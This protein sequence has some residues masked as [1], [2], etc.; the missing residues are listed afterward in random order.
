[1]IQ[2][3]VYNHLG[4]SGN[5]LPRF[6]PY[7]HDDGRANTWGTGG[8]SRRPGLRRGA[9]LHHRQRPDVAGRL[10][11]RR[12]S[13]GR[14]ARAG[15]PQR[16]CTC[17]R[18]WPT[19]VAALSA[20]L[21]RPLTLIAES[22]LNDPRLITPRAAGGYGLDAQWNDD[23]HHVLHVALTDETVGYYS[24]FGSARSDRQGADRWLLPRRHVLRRSA[25][26]GTARPRRHPRP[27]RPGD[28]SATPRTT[29]RSGTGPPATGSPDHLGPEDLAVAAVLVLTGPF[30]PMLFMGE[31]WAARTPWQF[32]TSHPEPELGEA[33]AAGPAGRV[34]PDG[35]GPGGRAEPAGRTDLPALQVGLGRA[36]T[37]PSTRRAGPVPAADRPAPRA[38]RTH[39]SAVRPDPGAGTTRT[40]G[41]W[42]CT[43]AASR[44]PSTSAPPRSRAAAAGTPAESCW[45]P[46]MPQ[47]DER[48]VAGDAA[49]CR[50]SPTLR[51][52]PGPGRLRRY[53]R[54]Q[55]PGI[56]ARPTAQL[57]HSLGP[58]SR[59][60]AFLTFRLAA[61]LT[62]HPSWARSARRAARV[63]EL[64]SRN[65]ADGAG[66]CGSASRSLLVAAASARPGGSPGRP[67]RRGRQ[68]PADGEPFGGG[69]GADA[70]AD[71]LDHRQPHPGGPATTSASAPAGEV[72]SVKVAEGDTVQEGPGTRHHRDRRRS[73]ADLASA[74]STLAQANARVAADE[75]AVDAAA[76]TDSTTDDTTAAAQLAAD[77]AAVATAKAGG[78]RRRGALAAATLTSPIDG[79]GRR[80]ERGG[81]RHRLGLVVSGPPRAVPAAMGPGLRGSGTG[82]RLGGSGRA[83]L[84]SNS[85]SSAPAR[86]SS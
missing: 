30:T 25:A 75:D 19:E 72:T 54:D 22:D 27:P 73:K 80:G 42:W 3:V 61:R 1:M 4:P 64:G 13:A 28:S 56:V 38:A 20:H 62:W 21:G 45:P 5:V 33:T 71:H 35:L 12:T 29:T 57:P 24:D 81:R 49:G 53:G 9:P 66:G 39:R 52:G 32:F 77:K 67:T 69:V 60:F 14:R 76:D 2:D 40:H 70:Q 16:R 41:G 7:L 10:P 48:T 82:G 47:V 18:S 86:R 83:A 6:G 58:P 15:R 84:G 68:H 74:K 36:R 31:E 46:P 11:R 85:S 50:P 23:F 34:R 44:S 79:S 51:P 17:S 78:H 63:A 43:A 8:Q 37:T 55:A 59:Q 26:T 65:S